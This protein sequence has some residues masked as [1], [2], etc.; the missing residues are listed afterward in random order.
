LLHYPRYV[1]DTTAS[2]LSVDQAAALSQCANTL[3]HRVDELDTALAHTTEVLTDVERSIETRRAAELA[4]LEARY[5]QE[6][7]STRA[8]ALRHS[9]MLQSARNQ[10]GRMH[11]ALR[12]RFEAWEKRIVSAGLACMTT[13]DVLIM[14]ARQHV[15]ADVSVVTTRGTSGAVL[16]HV[17]N[18]THL[19]NL[20]GMARFGDCVHLHH[21]FSVLQRELRFVDPR[22]ISQGG[23]HPSLWS[24]EQCTTWL[25]TV[26]LGHLKPTFAF[27][28][29]AGDTLSLLDCSQFGTLDVR[30]LD[31]KDDL[32]AALHAL[33]ASG[34]HCAALHA[35]RLLSTITANDRSA[36]PA[37]RVPPSHELVSFLIPMAETESTDV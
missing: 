23:D 28:R 15:Q 8:L 35:I 30:V 19:V 33:L 32:A 1:S 9:S 21:V 5:T 22:E 24:V 36:L 31:S 27:H 3:Q 4:A 25:D 11:A 12:P 20:L 10:L 17:T 29:I 37:S 14:C 2:V 26:G 7:A 18:P 6:R 13:E 34:M 16:Q